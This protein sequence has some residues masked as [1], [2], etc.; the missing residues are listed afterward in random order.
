MEDKKDHPWLNTMGAAAR[1]DVSI[2]TLRLWRRWQGFPMSAVVREANECFWNT[3][4]IDE[5]L[6]SRPLHKQGRPVRWAQTVNHPS[7]ATT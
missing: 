1:Y 4:E 5:W 7:L 6:R 2:D 3:E